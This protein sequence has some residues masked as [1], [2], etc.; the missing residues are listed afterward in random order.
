MILSGRPPLIYMHVHSPMLKTNKILGHFCLIHGYVSLMPLSAVA[1]VL[2]V[3]KSALCS[4][5][6]SCRHGLAR[7]SRSY[8]VP[9]L[10]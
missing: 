10:S 7:N 3:I 6:I 2:T 8:Y 5:I 9:V 1:A 4:N